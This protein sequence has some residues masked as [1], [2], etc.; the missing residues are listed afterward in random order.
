METPG[1]YNI[2]TFESSTS[3]HA[4]YQLLTKREYFAGIALQGLLA[5]SVPI[6]NEAEGGEAIDFVSRVAI[7]IADELINQLNKSK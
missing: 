5:S 3:P 7:T 1:T 2:D 6:P 4:N